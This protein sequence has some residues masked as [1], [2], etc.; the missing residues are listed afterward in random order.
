MDYRYLNSFVVLAEELHFGRAA[1]RLCITQPALSWHIKVLE[2][3]LGMALFLR[4]RRHVALT[5]AGERLAQEAR[6]SVNHYEKLL[7]CARSLREGF[8]GQLTLGYVG[9][10]ILDPALTRLTNGYRDLKPDIDIVIEEHNVNDQLTLL[11]GHQ[12]DVGLLR[13]PVPRY[14]GLKYLDVATRS[15]IAA[16]PHTHPLAG[17]DRIALESLSGDIFMVQKDPPGVGLGWSALNACALAK[18]VPHKILFTRDV[19][20]A[21]GLVSMGLGVTLVPETQRAVSLPG[22][23]YCLLE[24]PRATT[25]LTL[26]WPRYSKSRELK[27]FIHYVHELILPVPEINSYPLS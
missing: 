27:A 3:K 21:M 24:D 2:E 25:T 7:D 11:L 23:S 15:L 18:F 17:E 1:V 12:L 22:V 4:D 19:S 5:V 16:V 14:S 10:S 8:R 26:S 20:V 6:V 9:S 13:S